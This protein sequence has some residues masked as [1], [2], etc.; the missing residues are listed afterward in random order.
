M[1]PPRVVVIGA[2][3][4]IGARVTARLAGRHEVL[5]VVRRAGTDMTG[6]TYLTAD[7]GPDWTHVLPDAADVVIWLA[8]SRRYREFPA[9]APDMFRVNESALFAALEWARER[10]VRRF[11]YASTGSVYAPASSPLTEASP[12]GASS[13]YA[14]T[15]LNGETLAVQYGGLFEVVIG[16]VFGVYGPGQ[17]GMAVARV[18][19]AAASGRTV[20][21]TAGIGMELTP[22]FVDDAAEIFVRLVSAPLPSSPL[23]V[24]IAG[25]EATTLGA[26]A[27]M[28]A[29]ASGE[30]AELIHE[31]GDPA[32]II[33]DIGTLRALLPDL[34]FHG[35]ADGVAAT[36]AALGTAQRRSM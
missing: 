33:A 28:A 26:I 22:L 25:P 12:I 24:N 16:R 32:R 8:Q 9:G 3:G 4:F 27:E 19:E 23:I 10:G 29:R 6:V 20:P 15:K 1:T 5:A 13:F 34:M 31:A 36:V 2:G 35:L 11:I 21:L 14:A 17:A 7:L 30:Q 18:I